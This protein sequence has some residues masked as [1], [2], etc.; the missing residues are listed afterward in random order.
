MGNVDQ[1][2]VYS[3]RGKPYTMSLV[4]TRSNIESIVL[5]AAILDYFN[6][7]LPHVNGNDHI[8]FL[9][10]FN[11]YAGLTTVFLCSI[12]VTLY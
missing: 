5:V 8:V 2:G 11:A 6:A 3:S 7:T 10:T 1:R 9:C 12:T 4:S